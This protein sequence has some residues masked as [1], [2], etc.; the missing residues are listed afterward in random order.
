MKDLTD[1]SKD[2]LTDPDFKNRLADSND[3][4]AARYK[5]CHKTFKLIWEGKH[6]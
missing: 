1:F 6:Y 5:L 3:S 4:T 2:W